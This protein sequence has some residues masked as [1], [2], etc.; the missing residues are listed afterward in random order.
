MIYKHDYQRMA[1]DTDR[2]MITQSGNDYH[3][4]SDNKLACIYI[5]W[6]EERCPERLQA[7][8]DKGRIY[9]HIDERITECEKEKWK[10]WSKMRDTDPEYALAMKNADTT[11]VWQFENLFELQAEEIAIQTCL[12]VQYE[13]ER[14]TDSKV[15]RSF[16]QSKY[17]C[18]NQECKH[19]TGMGNF[20]A[21]YL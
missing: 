19:N 16:F 5:K 13:K 4:Y 11:K 8:T 2:M 7:E 1:L 15:I 17:D 12:L 3:D 21:D 18:C 20:F 10:I 9:V 14:L 6:A